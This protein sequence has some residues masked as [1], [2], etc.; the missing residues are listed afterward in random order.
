MTQIF[1]KK[2]M[3]KTAL[4]IGS[5]LGLG[6]IGYFVWKKFGKKSTTAPAENKTKSAVAK[7]E[8]VVEETPATTESVSESST[9]SVSELPT[10]EKSTAEVAVV[11]TDETASTPEDLANEA[12]L[13]A[14]E[15]KDMAEEALDKKEEEDDAAITDV[16]ELTNK[17]KR[18]QQREEKRRRRLENK[19]ERTNLRK[20]RREMSPKE[21]MAA[22]KARKSKAQGI[23][24]KMPLGILSKLQMKSAKRAMRKATGLAGAMGGSIKR[25]KRGFGREMSFD[26]DYYF[27]FDNSQTFT[28]FSSEDEDFAF[29]GLNF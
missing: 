24:S 25:K 19:I 9:K 6:V 11:K 18:E 1:K 16:K 3:N 10:T 4:T 7:A 14:E 13:D 20:I 15:A 23:L 8:E 29:N 22:Y 5:I 26:G 2:I 21:K 27:S 28:N 12:D 17:Q